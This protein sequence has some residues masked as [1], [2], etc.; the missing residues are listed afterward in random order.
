MKVELINATP[1]IETVIAKASGI[2]YANETTDPQKLIRRLKL[3]RH[4][5]TF[6]F[7]HITFQV[8]E[9]SRSC[10]MQMLRHAFLDYLQRSQRYV[11]EFQ[12]D[13]VTPPNIAGN[14]KK[15]NFANNDFEV[16]DQTVE[17][18]YKTHMQA[19]QFVYDLLLDSGIK[20]EDARYVLPN[21]CHTAM[22]IVGN[23]QAWY[24]FLYGDAGRLQ[25]AAQWEIRD[26]ALQIE[27][28][29][30]ILAPNIFGEQCVK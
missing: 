10:S 5:A 28:H 1:N 7:A 24:D 26:I 18:V 23:I 6:R 15:V 2:C 3:S 11:K 27:R 9:F 14:T 16:F 19:C 29:L 13:Y 4:L 30:I 12:F 20:A 8:S 22:N 25:K 21:A 17:D